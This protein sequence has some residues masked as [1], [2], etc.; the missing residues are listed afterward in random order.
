M[1]PY[2][3]I[4]FSRSSAL[5]TPTTSE[6]HNLIATAVQWDNQIQK[7]LSHDIGNDANMRPGPRVVFREKTPTDQLIGIKL[8][9]KVV[10]TEHDDFGFPKGS[11]G[12]NLLDHI[13]KRCLMEG[14][15]CDPFNLFH[16]NFPKRP[17]GLGVSSPKHEHI[18]FAGFHLIQSGFSRSID[19][20]NHQDD[21]RRSNDDSNI[22]KG[23]AF[24]WPAYWP[25]PHGYCLGD[26]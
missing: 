4:L 26:S 6:G 11:S 17:V 18:F 21:S 20:R 10:N 7:V 19:N 5:K 13:G 25:R 3:S 8:K 15:S 1:S 16:R 2:W 14:Q 12:L 24:Y 9:V 22:E 23:I